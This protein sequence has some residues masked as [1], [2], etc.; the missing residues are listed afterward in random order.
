MKKWELKGSHFLNVQDI[1][2]QTCEFSGAEKME[3]L[4]A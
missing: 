4:T 3:R 1:E 2:N